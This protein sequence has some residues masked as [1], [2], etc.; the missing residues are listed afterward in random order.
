MSATPFV[1][2]TITASGDVKFILD[3]SAFYEDIPLCAQDGSGATWGFLSAQYVDKKTSL[4]LHRCAVDVQGNTVPVQR[5]NRRKRRTA[6]HFENQVTLIYWEEERMKLGVKRHANIKCFCNGRVQMTGLR[7]I[8]EGLRIIDRIRASTPQSAI[9]CPKLAFEVTD[10]KVCLINSN[11]Y[12]GFPICREALFGL[13]VGDLNLVVL[14]EPCIY[15]GVKLSFMW[16]A[17]KEQQGQDA[18]CVCS[19]EDVEHGR[20]GCSCMRITCAIFRSGNVIITGARSIQQVHDAY[21]F[22][23]DVAAKYRG[24]IQQKA[25][26]FSQ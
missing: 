16:N 20:G 23:L 18:R 22:L 26:C 14:Y 15:Q 2:S 17:S 10:F 6:K 21:H 12:I 8:E 1:I 7:S 13:L 11:F 3:M 19:R 25:S 24:H 5:S 9:V 4:L